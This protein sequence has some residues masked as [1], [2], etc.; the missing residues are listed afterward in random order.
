MINPPD[1]KF[2]IIQYLD[3]AKSINDSV[4]DNVGVTGN[5]S[6]NYQAIRIVEIARMLQLD[7][8]ES[9][10]GLFE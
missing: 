10:K 2:R 9:R 3:M 4:F 1:T 6:L 5:E 8:L 7:D